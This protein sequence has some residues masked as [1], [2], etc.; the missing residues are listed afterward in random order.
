MFYKNYLLGIFC[1]LLSNCTGLETASKKPTVLFDNSFT[2]KGFALVYNNKLYKDKTVSAKLDERSLIIFQKNLK[3]NTLVK[4]TNILNNK[5]L[6][7]KVGKKSNY[8]DFNNAVI[9]ERIMKELEL[10]QDHPYVEIK[11]I[12]ENSL[13]VAKKAKTFEEEREVADKVPVN[14][15]SIDDLKNKKK[16][17]KNKSV[18]KFSYIIKIADFYFNDTALV[19]SKRITSETKIKD[20]NIKKISGREYRVYLGP[21]N[22]INSLQQSFNDVQILDFE[23]IEILKYD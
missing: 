13:F 8:P 22:N 23:N 2:K 5:F 10:D 3:K 11:S 7:A 4:I 18:K 19:M 15:I 12:S 6:L 14:S 16:T 17:T 1:L 21:F 20:V 9:S